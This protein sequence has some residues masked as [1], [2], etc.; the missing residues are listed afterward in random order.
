[1]YIKIFSMTRVKSEQPKRVLFQ[2][3]TLAGLKFICIII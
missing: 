1:M 2:D 3:I